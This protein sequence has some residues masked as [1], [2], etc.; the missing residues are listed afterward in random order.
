MNDISQYI[1]HSIAQ[2]SSDDSNCQKS[3]VFHE[4]SNTQ[5]IN[6]IQNTS[7]IDT[8]ESKFIILYGIA[9]SM[10]F[11]HSHNII[12]CNLNLKFIY[13]DDNFYPI[14][15][16]FDFMKHITDESPKIILDRFSKYIGSP[17]YFAPEIFT[18]KEYSKSSDVFAFAILFYEILNDGIDIDFKSFPDL[19]KKVFLKKKRLE[20][21]YLQTK[22]P[23]LYHGLIEKCWSNDPNERPTFDDI[24]QILK[25]DP[26]LNN[27]EKYPRYVQFIEDPF[28]HLGFLKN[29]GIPNR[30]FPNNKKKNCLKHFKRGKISYIN[31]NFDDIQEIWNKDTQERYC[32]LSS[33]NDLDEFTSN[34]ITNISQEL[35]VFSQLNHPSIAKFI[36]YNR[37]DIYKFEKPTIIT[38]FLPNESLSYFLKKDRHFSFW[39]DTQKLIIIYGIASGMSYLHSHNIIHRDLKPDYIYFDEFFFPKIFGFLLSKELQPNEDK[40][41]FPKI[42][43]TPIYL[44]PEVYLRK[45]YS[46]AS[47]VYAFSLIVYEI[48]TNEKPFNDLINV[49]QI[50]EKVVNKKERPQFNVSIPD[51]YR[52]LIE[53]CWS[54]E[55]VD[56]PTF[57]EIVENLKKNPEFITETV[58]SDDYQKYIKLIDE[59]LVTFHPERKMTYNDITDQSLEFFQKNDPI[60]SFKYTALGVFETEYDNIPLD[61]KYVDLTNFEK[62]EFVSRGSYSGVYKILDK[63][64][65]KYYA[66]KEF[67]NHY[68][69]DL[70]RELNY[71]IEIDHPSVIKFVGFSPVNFKRKPHP[72]IVTEY[73]FNGSLYDTL[74]LIRKNENVPDWDDTKK[75][76]NIYGIA[77]VL[78]YLHSKNIIYRDLKPDNIL[79]DDYLCP[80]LIDFE[81][82]KRITDENTMM[83][84]T[85]LYMAPEVY[86]NTFY[87]KPVDVYSFGL[88]MYEIMT[89]TTAYLNQSQVLDEVFSNDYRPKIPEKVPQCYRNLISKCWVKDPSKRPTFDEIVELL[90]TDPNF[91]TDDVDEEEFK[92]YIKYIDNPSQNFNQ[93]KNYLQKYNKIDIYSYIKQDIKAKK[94]TVKVKDI[95]LNEYQK[96]K[97]I[98]SGSFGTVYKVKDLKTGNIFAAKISKVYLTQC[99]DDD[100]RNLE[101]EVDIISKLKHPA[102]LKFI[103]FTV[104]DFKGKPKPTIIT[105]LVPNGSLED[106]LELERR[107]CGNKNW[108]ETKKLINIYG[109]AS[110]MSYLHSREIIHR[111]LKP[112]NILLDEFLFPKI[113]DFGL[114]KIIGN[115]DNNI[116]S[117]FKG[118]YAYSA[119][120]MFRNEYSKKGDVFAFA[121]IVYEIVTNE[122]PYSNLSP[123]QL[124]V[125]VQNG[126]RPSFKYDI[127]TC[128]RNLITSCWKDNPK[129]RPS[130]EEIV[131]ILRTEDEFTQNV[132]IN[133]FFDYV[134]LIDESKDKFGFDIPHFDPIYSKSD[135]KIVQLVKYKLLDKI[136]DQINYEKYE[137][138]SKKTKEKC[139]A[140][141]SKYKINKIPDQ[142]MIDLSHE[143]NIISQI[144]H[145]LFAKFVGYSP[146]NFN[147]SQHPVIVTET[148]SNGTLRKFI[149]KENNIELNDTDK[150]IIIYGIASALQFLHSHEII[151]RNLN[152]DSIL[153][154]DEFH[155]KITDFQ[156]SLNVSDKQEFTGCYAY[157]APE[158]YN[159]Q[160]SKKSDV[161][162]F[163]MIVYEI[164]EN[165][166]VYDGLPLYK[167]QYQTL[168][169]N[170]PD[171]TDNFPEF[172]RRIIEQCWSSEATMRP[173]F[174]Q[175]VNTLKTNNDFITEKVDQNKFKEYVECIDNFQKND[176][177]EIISKQFDISKWQQEKKKSSQQNQEEEEN[178]TNKNENDEKLLNDQNCCENLKFNKV[179]I[180]Y[181]KVDETTE[182]SSEFLD[183]SKFKLGELICKQ[184]YSKTYSVISKETGVTYSCKIS[185]VR[186]SQFSRDDLINLSREVSIISQLCHPSFLKFIGYSPVDFKGKNHPVIVTELALNGSLSNLLNSLRNKLTIPRWNETAK[187]ITIYGIAA[188]MKYLHSNNI[189]HRDLNPENVFLDGHLFPKIGDFGLSTRN[190]TSDT[191]TYQ[192]TTGM[193]GNPIYSAPE[194]LQFNN[195]SKSGDV[196]SFAYIV[197]EIVTE[198][199]PFDGIVNKNDIFNE[200]V[201]KGNRPE[202]PQKVAPCYRSLIQKCWAQEPTERPSFEAI[203]EILRKDKSIISDGV[204]S[205]GFVNYVDFIDESK[206]SFDSGKRILDL[207]E[208]IREKSKISEIDEERTSDRNYDGEI[209]MKIVENE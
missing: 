12:H 4:L 133:E 172:Y 156:F 193:K 144:N 54:Q 131:Q 7:N 52:N 163:A 95:Y 168:N 121:I 143:I 22:I 43:G 192:S 123:Y 83:R 90:R 94:I 53:K 122:F 1:K 132:D 98:G 120:E 41:V 96:Q 124:A 169:G 194:I 9:S 84:G 69:L 74:N 141:I 158:T 184:N 88:V 135:I 11:L 153:L 166:S 6:Y 165:K 175:I 178:E 35:S 73:S 65:G 40:E 206:K 26:Y 134:D 29:D 44:S 173:S 25:T 46:K 111:D 209:M 146:N 105:E 62:Q 149:Q 63:R 93:G 208:F 182:I 164:L 85:I 67:K 108:D 3:V 116:R 152:L 115:D 66:A 97:S 179:S 104:N 39:D 16:G 101:R 34:G 92:N 119:P 126:F 76:I 5:T 205:E 15:G 17:K 183:L 171:F 58:N 60:R 113:S 91:I 82:S 24:V 114:S 10:S 181:E 71:L 198:E 138:L 137:I 18:R 140:R 151:H 160:Y 59:S 8:I 30:V 77:S 79:F 27:K 13:L 136:D 112:A 31:N 186:M 118:T 197:F 201:L 72:V 37:C 188:G 28:V 21:E 103:G 57:S 86:L 106:I 100:A 42:Q 150:L 49:H 167:I 129:E 174:D 196:Y 130:F 20:L 75:L 157:S 23:L 128:Y 2:L 81:C 36:G 78:Q 189:L 176:K 148:T 180:N 19:M 117:G 154:D 55:P 177:T 127:P 38:E 68:Y 48:M 33:T 195:Y 56:R 125:Q 142:M 51:C 110:A 107:C 159:L 202:I 61:L 109:I 32:I 204:K 199:I 170:R 155:P 190:H 80:K 87:G 99:T 162:S 70:L 64:T 191:M 187:L 200:I 89:N 45:E 147:A 50:I 102:I 161:Y 47:D 203:V 185:T 139:I 207:S 14:L 145:P